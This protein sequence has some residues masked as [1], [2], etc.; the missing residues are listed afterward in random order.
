MKDDLK[1]RYAAA[2]SSQGLQKEKGMP[3]QLYCFD[4]DGTL[5]SSY[6]DTKSR[7]INDWYLL[8]GRKEALRDIKRSGARVAIITN[9]ASVAYGYATEEEV[10][11][12]FSQVLYRFGFSGLYE[13]LDDAGGRIDHSRHVLFG[14]GED[15][16][17]L[18]FG[19]T[20]A[21]HW[22][23]PHNALATWMTIH[24]C[25]HH[26]KATVHPY[27]NIAE[28]QR[29]KPSPAMLD[30]AMRIHGV[31]IEDTVFVGDMDSDEKASA[32][33]GVYYLHADDVEW[34][35]LVEL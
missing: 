2:R 13:T 33:A 10:I 30:E 7:N 19:R 15:N 34:D 31:N 4:L 20:P 5:I 9:Q 21:E 25:C 35:R 14:H 24:V 6:M 8:P 29:R 23:A 11:E 27:D 1:L 18:C 26:P 28:A 17:V 3:T 22:Y 12:K 16:S 32:A